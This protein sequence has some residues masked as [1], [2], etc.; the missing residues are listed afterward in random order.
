[1]REYV[2]PEFHGQPVHQKNVFGY[3]TVATWDLIF[4]FRRFPIP[5]QTRS[6]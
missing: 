2:V 1:M 6:F 3:I 5:L 4:I